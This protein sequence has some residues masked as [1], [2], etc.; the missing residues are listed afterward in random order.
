MPA[1]HPNPIPPYP[2]QPYPVISANMDYSRAPEIARTYARLSSDPDC[3]RNLD[4]WLEDNGT[5][6]D[7][8]YRW[9]QAR[10]NS[11]NWELPEEPF[12]PNDFSWLDEIDSPFDWAM[13]DNLHAIG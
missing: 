3:Q 1:F 2:S 9:V 11:D 8:F 4:I 12:D 6:L 5:S 7:S 13:L 10:L